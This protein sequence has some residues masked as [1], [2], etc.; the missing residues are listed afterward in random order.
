MLIFE[1]SQ[2]E[3]LKFENNRVYEKEDNIIGWT[4]QTINNNEQ[5]YTKFIRRLIYMKI[6]N[7][8]IFFSL[9]NF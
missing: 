2:N 5:L 9:Y 3:T 6:N 8:C 4:M 7:A 1:T